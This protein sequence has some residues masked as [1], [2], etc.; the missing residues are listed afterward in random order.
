MIR[1]SFVHHVECFNHDNHI[2]Q[3]AEHEQNEDFFVHGI[4]FS[5]RYVSYAANCGYFD[6][7]EPVAEID[8]Y[9]TGGFVDNFGHLA[10]EIVVVH[11]G[12]NHTWSNVKSNGYPPHI[13]LRR[14]TSDGTNR[15]YH[16]VDSTVRFVYIV[17][18][19]NV[20][21]SQTRQKSDERQRHSDERQFTY[22]QVEEQ[23]H[24]FK[25][26]VRRFV[27]GLYGG[28]GGHVS[29][30]RARASTPPLRR[31]ERS[32]TTLFFNVHRG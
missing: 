29:R 18:L 19:E 13:R 25:R 8:K 2:Q 10:D 31:T 23:Q 27:G 28:L 26:V 3:R 21:G 4:V 14:H 7:I 15:R 24:V 1:H 20:R 9:I 22:A 6:E 17:V 16:I 12:N 11:L 32:S 5:I 30:A